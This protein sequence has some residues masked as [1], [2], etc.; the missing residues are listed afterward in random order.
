MSSAVSCVVSASTYNGGQRL[1]MSVHRAD[2]RTG[3]AGHVNAVLAAI[4]Q[5][6]G[7][8]EAPDDYDRPWTV[9][10]GLVAGLMVY[11]ISHSGLRHILLTFPW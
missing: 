4:G 11:W 3:L 10:V 9:F 7:R 5:V 8:G 1:V 6:T 2:G